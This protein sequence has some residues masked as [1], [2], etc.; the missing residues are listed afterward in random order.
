MSLDYIQSRE[1]EMKHSQNE[2]FQQIDQLIQYAVEKNTHKRKKKK[3][4][5]EKEL[6]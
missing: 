1:S 3:G 4:K 6:T 2:V 5:K